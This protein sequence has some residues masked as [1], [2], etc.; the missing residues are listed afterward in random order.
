MP[1]VKDRLITK[2][3]VKLVLSMLDKD[4]V[5]GFSE[6]ARRHP[7]NAELHFK[8]TDSGVDKPLD[9][10]SRQVRLAVDKEVV[11]FLMDKEMEYEIN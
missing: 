7:G 3:T 8:I 4:F 2:F 9:F 5:A 11:S 6:L 1:E 10:M